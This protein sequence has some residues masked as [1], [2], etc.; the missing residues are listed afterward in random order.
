MYLK[1]FFNDIN[2]HS[3]DKIYLIILLCFS[4]LLTYS[5]IKFH[6]TRGAF[7]SDIFI[8]LASALDFAGLNVNHIS[9]LSWIH[10]S[11]VIF[12]LTSLLFRLGLVDITAIFIVTGIFGI[13]GIFGM[14]VFLKM[15][16]FHLLNFLKLFY[17]L[18]MVEKAGEEMNHL[19]F[20]SMMELTQKMK[21]I[22]NKES[23]CKS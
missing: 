14:Y 3:K 9:D 6:Q 21:E 11:P 23:K 15:R 10:N 18:L 17:L 4:L 22:L 5:M 2:L 12:F 8:Y 1:S 19:Y 13:I 16:F 7:N 20:L